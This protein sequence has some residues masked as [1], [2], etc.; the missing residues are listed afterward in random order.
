MLRNSV[1]VRTLALFVVAAAPGVAVRAGDITVNNLSN[2]GVWVA[3]F[4]SSPPSSDRICA[5]VRGEMRTNDKQRI[6]FPGND[7]LVRIL[8]GGQPKGF[9]QF[10]KVSM[11]FCDAAPFQVWTT[12]DRNIFTLKSKN[13]NDP[14]VVTNWR[15]G[16]PL[17]PGWSI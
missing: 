15:W 3:V 16:T 2:D 13:G 4:Y 9:N 12:E 17:P 8:Q 6:D 7:V 14:E 5:F 1:S 11:P 10:Q